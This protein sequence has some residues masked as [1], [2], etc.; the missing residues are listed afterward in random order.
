[1]KVILLADVQGVGKQQQVID[2]KSGYANNFLFKKGLAVVANDENMKVLNEQ[3]AEKRAQEAAIK[4]QAEE[5]K[6]TVKEKSVKISASG[7]PDGK[8]YG[9]I[10]SMDIS[11]A[12]TEQYNVDVDK[13]KVVLD[14]P[15]K[16]AGTYTVKLKLHPKVETTVYVVVTVK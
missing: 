7:G 1:M 8:L 12:L 3:L 9:S 10:T 5:V 15:I 11:A 4:A 13:R 16:S 2:V 6:E 14:S